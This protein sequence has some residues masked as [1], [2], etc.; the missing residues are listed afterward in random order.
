MITY[1]NQRI[2]TIGENATPKEGT[3][4]RFVVF[5]YEIMMKAMR[6]LTPTTHHVW[7]YLN[8]YAYE[9]GCEFALS[10]KDAIKETGISASSYARAVA[11]LKEKGYLIHTTDNRYNF[12]A[13]P[14][15]GN[16]L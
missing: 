12:Y 16:E 1:P 3:N 8:A 11:E 6:D 7:S 9:N 5:D 10:R 14:A 15:G 13:T 4:V 2:I